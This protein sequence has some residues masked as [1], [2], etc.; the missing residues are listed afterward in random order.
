MF[1][2][3]TLLGMVLALAVIVAG[4][5]ARIMGAETLFGLIQAQELHFKAGYVLAE[6]TFL[7]LLMSWWQAHCRAAAMIA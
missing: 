5:L 6:V 2:K 4:S 7:V 3:T 1:R